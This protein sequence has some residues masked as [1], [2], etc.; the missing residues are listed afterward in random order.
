MQVLDAPLYDTIWAGD[1]R[2]YDAQRRSA[3]NH[4]GQYPAV[5][6]RVELGPAPAY[7]PIKP[8]PFWA[9]KKDK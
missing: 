8:R 6:P 7:A 1:A 2:Q 3:K 5:D 9:R 4:P